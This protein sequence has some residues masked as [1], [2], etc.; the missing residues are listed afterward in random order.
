MEGWP[1]TEFLSLLALAQHFGL[2][3]PGLD[4]KFLYRRLLLLLLR[5]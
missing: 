5:L 1:R 2:P 4:Q 3:T